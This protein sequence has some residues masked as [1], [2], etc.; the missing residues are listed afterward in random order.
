MKLS[1]FLAQNAKYKTMLSAGVPKGAV[2]QKIIADGKK[3]KDGL[4]DDIVDDAQQ[5]SAAVATN[6]AAAAPTTLA[7][8][9][10][11][12]MALGMKKNLSDAEKQQLTQLQQQRDQLS[13]SVPKVDWRAEQAKQ[14][15]TAQQAAATYKP[16]T[17][18]E[19]QQE[20]IAE[21]EERI[22]SFKSRIATDKKE[23]D[24]IALVRSLKSHP[25]KASGSEYKQ[26]ISKYEA[27]LPTKATADAS[28]VT[29]KPLAVK[30][31]KERSTTEKISLLEKEEN[32]TAS[33]VMELKRLRE[34]LK[35]EP[36]PST[37]LGTQVKASMNA[38]TEKKPGTG[39]GTQVSPAKP[40]VFE[41][42]TDTPPPPAKTTQ[43]AKPMVDGNK[44]SD[45]SWI[46]K[47]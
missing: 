32:L 9:N 41:K 37:G 29:Q 46:K 15:A 4:V 27:M 40:V 38:T 26:M 22:E 33:Q 6:S 30:P 10:A 23:Q 14:A 35:T 13:A 8:V 2:L 3:P 47:T 43:I 1:E 28:A 45:S 11:K 24:V 17:A 5:N 42:K 7:G 36:K 12:I 44:K 39:L 34:L 16:R 19:R 20:E 25:T 18:Q 31:L 21:L